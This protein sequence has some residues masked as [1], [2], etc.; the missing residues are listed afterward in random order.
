[1]KLVKEINH[2]GTIYDIFYCRKSVEIKDCGSL[3][4]SSLF[5]SDVLSNRQNK[6]SFN[7]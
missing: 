7:L 4:A 2:Y 5:E 6:Y 3:Q 1:M